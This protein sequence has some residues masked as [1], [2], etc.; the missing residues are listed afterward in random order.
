MLFGWDWNT[1]DAVLA[2][3]DEIEHLQGEALVELKELR[4][5][6][7][8]EFTN[9]CRRDQS[10]IESHCP[11]VFVLRPRDADAK[12]I[13]KVLADAKKLVAGQQIDLQLYCQAPGFWHPTE[14]GGRYQVDEPAKWIS[15]TAPYLKSLLT[16]LKYATPI[17]GPWFNVLDKDTYEKVLKADI[18]LL[19]AIVKQTPDIIEDQHADVELAE[20]IGRVDDPERVEGAALRAL[21]K[22]LDDKDPKQEWGGLTKVLTPEGHYLWLCEYHAAEY[23]H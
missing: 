3:L 22:L 11:N 1:K 8:R 12:G 20:R 13:R 21:R 19:D 15:A 10:L 9:A 17:I 6:A 2:R 18:E 14:K 4:A 5:L 23:L 7:Q 16:V